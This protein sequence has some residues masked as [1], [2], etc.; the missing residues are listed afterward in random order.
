MYILLRLL[1]K[2]IDYGDDRGIVFE[3]ELDG[4]G[5]GETPCVGGHLVG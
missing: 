3:T 1:H 2:L 4:V 5:W